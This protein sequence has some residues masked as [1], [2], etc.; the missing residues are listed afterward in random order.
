MKGPSSLK[1][2]KI[3]K[4]LKSLFPPDKIQEIGRTSGYIKRN[5]KVDIVYFLWGLI[6]GFGINL[7]RTLAGAKRRYQEIT[8]TELSY[9]SWYE[10]FTPELVKFLRSCVELA[11][12]QMVDEVNRP[13]G[14]KLKRFDDVVIQDSTVIRLHKALT[15]IWPATRTKVVAAGVKV[16][17]VISAVAN[18]IRTVA[19]HGERTSEVKTIRIGP[20]IKNKIMLLDLGF[21]KYQLFARIIDNGG[22]FV[23]RLKNN[24]DPMIEAS[25]RVHR[26][27]AIDLAGKRWS[28]VK[29]L[30]KREVLDAEVTMAFFRRKYKE[31][32][33]Q[34]ELN[35]RLVAIYNVEDRRYHVYIT[36]I[37][38]D[39]LCAEDIASL[40]SVCWEI[41]LVFKELKSKYRLDLVKTT[42]KNIA[43][44]LIWIGILTMLVS[45]RL[46]NLLRA[47]VPRDRVHRYTPLLWANIFVETSHILL[48]AMTEFLHS[49]R[50]RNKCFDRLS[51]L[52]EYQA[53]SPH[54]NR[55]R[56]SDKLEA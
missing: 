19:I 48:D 5:R 7:E 39:T 24:A 15:K 21:F 51:R 33:S 38:Q 36:N 13:L 17:T 40:Y 55:K 56:L 20:W 25:L 47:A 23:S 28:E 54:V 18:G 9:S 29:G 41:E 3:P 32:K 35:L 42:N 8:E 53:M 50:M 44:A 52:W 11:L 2:R 43:E 45:R 46:F 10:R 4:A 12:S 6:L 1:P 49:K 37:P 26:G 14:K 16:A 27:R 31:K 30:L 22:F 34:D